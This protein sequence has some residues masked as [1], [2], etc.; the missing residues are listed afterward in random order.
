MR[1]TT[2][3]CNKTHNRKVALF[4]NKMKRISSIQYSSEQIKWSD[5]FIILYACVCVCANILRDSDVLL[6]Q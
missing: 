2:L 6:N 5:S 4:I 3:S 1:Q